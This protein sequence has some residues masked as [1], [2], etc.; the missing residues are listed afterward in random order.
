VSGF[1]A[2]LVLPAI[3]A[4]NA[5]ILMLLFDR[6]LGMHVF[7]SRRWPAVANVGGASDFN[8]LDVATNHD[9]QRVPDRQQRHVLPGRDATISAATGGA[10]T[11]GYCSPRAR[12][13]VHL[14]EARQFGDMSSRGIVP[15]H[16]LKELWIWL[17]ATLALHQRQHRA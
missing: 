10:G 16:I 7:E 13:R 3:P 14:W 9:L 1:N 6:L 12:R 2:I 15:T 8:S 5:S 4:R 17:S 11:P